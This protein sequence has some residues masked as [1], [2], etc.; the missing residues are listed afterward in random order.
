MTAWEDHD[1]E[2]HWEFYTGIHVG[3]YFDSYRLTLSGFDI[4]VSTDG[5]T[6]LVNDPMNNINGSAF[7]TIGTNHDERGF[8]A[9]NHRGGWWYDGACGGL[10]RPTGHYLTEDH[11][12]N[13]EGI[14]W[15]IYTENRSYSWKS[16][17]L[18]LVKAPTEA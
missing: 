10:A 3:P 13:Y 8:C 15:W 16:L 6:I 5:D 12:T 1:F 18:T 14:L 4:S 17:D 11:V 2:E 9:T 7:N